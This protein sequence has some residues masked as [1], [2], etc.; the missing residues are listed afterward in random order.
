MPEE[1]HQE[2]K[3]EE[4]INNFFTASL[5][6]FVSV[7]L[8]GDAPPIEADELFSETHQT[9]V[10]LLSQQAVVYNQEEHALRV[11]MEEEVQEKMT[12]EREK[13]WDKT[14]YALTSYVC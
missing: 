3:V 6:E 2:R 10:E 4:I 8:T 1:R 13:G 5:F 14:M 9:L 11:L 12:E 7:D